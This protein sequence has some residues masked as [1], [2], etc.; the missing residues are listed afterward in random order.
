MFQPAYAVYTTAPAG[1]WKLQYLAAVVLVYLR[2][3]DV[4][5]R[6]GPSSP[7]IEA[8]LEPLQSLFTIQTTNPSSCESLGEVSGRF[9][10]SD[11]CS[12]RK[13]LKLPG[14]P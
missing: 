14:A 5:S 10:L 11:P 8:Q 13:R 6:C 3:Y 2:I 7:V 9:P 1:P 4:H 12:G